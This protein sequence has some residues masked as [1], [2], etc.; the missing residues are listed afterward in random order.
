MKHTLTALLFGL[1]LSAFA[2]TPT[3]T[4]V[5]ARQ[6]YPWNGKVDITYTVTGDVAAETV[7][8]GFVTPTLK[9]TA[10]DLTTGN[11]YPAMSLTGDTGLSSG[12]HAVVWDMNADGLTF[13]SDD[14]VFDVI[15]KGIPTDPYC[16][17]DLSDGENASSYPITY[18]VNP[19]TGGFNTDEYKTTKL[20]LRRLEPG[21]V[22]TRDAT[23]TKPFYVGLFE[24]TQKQWELVTGSNPSSFSGDT[25]PVEW[26][27]YDAIRGSTLGSRWPASNA[28]DARSFLGR[29]RAR[30]GLDFDLPTEAQWEYACR[31]GTTT[32][33]SYGNAVDGAYMWYSDNSSSQTHEVG[34][35]L[36][37]AWG[38]YDMHG[39]VWEWCLDWYGGSLSGNDPV[40]SSSGSDRVVRGGSWY[41]DA[42]FCTSSS[43]YGGDPS[44]PSSNAI[45]FRLVRTLSN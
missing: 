30:T 20:V 39:N 6:R 35:K 5:T 8:R 36:P 17:I 45:G 29:L 21:S 33:Y 1:A 26:V 14:M 10:T 11:T 40:G 37:N 42:D 19:P 28:V 22:P 32:T 2:D 44:N 3:I 7:A 27:S 15:C 23:I 31:A 41:N 13:Q 4:D 25:R 9:V 18:L 16:I 24:V 34:T 43:R 12:T 38:L